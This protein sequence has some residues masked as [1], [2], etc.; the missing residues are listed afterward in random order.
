MITRDHPSHPSSTTHPQPTRPETPAALSTGSTAKGWLARR[1]EA[2]RLRRNVAA[3]Q[4][5]AHRVELL[6]PQWRIVDYHPEDPDFLAV[7]PGGIFQVT[8]ADHGRSRVQIAGEV[9]Q[10][11]G[12]RPPYVTLARR[13]AARI[14]AQ[15]SRLAGRRIPVIPVVAFMGTGE[16]VY[17]GQPPKGC[18]VSSYRD[19]GKALNAHGSRIAPHTIEKLTSLAGHVDSGTVGQFL[20]T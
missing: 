7:G 19:I 16:I 6:G 11:D 9:V 5:V 20:P 8:V 13:D 15:M 18:V 1:R 14:S 12:Q 3:T 4:R 17:Y 10:I 2:R